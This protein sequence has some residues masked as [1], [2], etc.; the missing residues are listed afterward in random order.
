MLPVLSHVVRMVSAGDYSA[1]AHQWRSGP[2]GVDVLTLVL[3]N[4]FNPVTGDWTRRAYL[5]FGVDHVEGVGWLGLVP[6]GV[7]LW[8]TVRAVR[9]RVLRPLVVCA[10]CYLVW[11]FGSWLTVGGV[12][13]GLILPANFF[14]F[15]PVLSNARIPG[16]ALVVVFLAMGLL[17]ARLIASLPRERQGRLAAML[18]LVLVI[19]FCPAPVATVALDRP[20]IY[21]AIPPENGVVLELPMGLRDGFGEIG[22]FDER[23]LLHQMTHGHPLVGGFLAR[24]PQ[25]IK[26]R[27]ADL[28][29]IRSLLAMSDGQS[30]P[31]SE[32]MALSSADA[33]Q[34][35]KNVGVR[36]VVLDHGA[37]SP[38][39][40]AFVA[41]LHL[42]T[43][44]RDGSRELLLLDEQ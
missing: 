3:G 16:R 17:T 42:S 33:T 27:Y 34:A 10:W 8:A 29:V 23:T 14:G 25:S 11:A 38:Q 43:L 6:T 40:S 32:D 7:L 21:A 35:L 28:P 39:L 24:L 1:P 9:D 4:P 36:Y 41:S 31:T 20:A 12:S 15:V 30:G 18:A 19:D 13:T 2:A 22:A 5:A 44:Q 37:A 26:R